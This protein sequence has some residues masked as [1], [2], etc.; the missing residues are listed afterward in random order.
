MFRGVFK[1]RRG[2]S[3]AGR[4]GRTE[5]DKDESKAHPHRERFAQDGYSK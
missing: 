1:G 3:P 5:Q 2:G 4:H